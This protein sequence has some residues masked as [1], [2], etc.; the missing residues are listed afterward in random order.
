MPLLWSYNNWFNV[1]LKKILKK[2]MRYNNSL[3][4]TLFVR[5]H[6][7]KRNHNDFAY[8]EIIKN[9]SDF[10]KWNLP[11]VLAL[12]VTDVTTEAIMTMTKIINIPTTIDRLYRLKHGLMFILNLP[13]F[14]SFWIKEIVEAQYIY[15]K[16]KVKIIKT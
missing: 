14:W 10:L 7:I 9:S 16:G 4:S 15:Q 3:Q 11:F 13:L 8:K 2:C 12:E 6:I 5:S 1:L